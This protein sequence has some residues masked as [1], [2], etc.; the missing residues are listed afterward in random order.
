MHHETSSAPQTYEK[1]LDKAYALMKRL[2]LHTVKTG[3][4]G[5]ILPKGEYHHGQWM[6][7]HYQKV[8]ET[9][10]KYQIAVDAHEPIKGT[11]LQRTWPEFR[12][13]RNAWSRI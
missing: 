3:Y 8:I 13:R 10:A 5:K 12:S 7:N 9:A 2:G 6:I 1:Q 11:G 4:V